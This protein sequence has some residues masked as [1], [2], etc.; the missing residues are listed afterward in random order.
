MRYIRKLQNDDPAPATSAPPPAQAPPAPAPAETLLERMQREEARKMERRRHYDEK[1]AELD[2]Q[3]KHDREQL[4]MQYEAKK[5]ELRA[6]YS[7]VAG[8]SASAGAGANAGL[9]QV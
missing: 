6:K 8:G 7:D 2:L 4:E 5:E 3:L 9:S 1:L